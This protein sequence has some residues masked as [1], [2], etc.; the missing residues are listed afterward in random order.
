MY[1]YMWTLQLIAIPDKR[2][3]IPGLQKCTGYSPHCNEVFMPIAIKYVANGD[4][5]ICDVIVA[6]L[7]KQLSLVVNIKGIAIDEERACIQLP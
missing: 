3:C 2:P 7:N 4:I 6:C 1:T 5:I